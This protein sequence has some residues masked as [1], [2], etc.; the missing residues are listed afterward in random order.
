MLGSAKKNELFLAEIS[1]EQV[2]CWGHLPHSK[3]RGDR[4]PGGRMVRTEDTSSTRCNHRWI[5]EQDLS[6]FPA[7]ETQVLGQ[8]LSRDCV[9]WQEAGLTS[10]EWFRPAPCRGDMAVDPSWQAGLCFAFALPMTSHHRRAGHRP[11][12]MLDSLCCGDMYGLPHWSCGDVCWRGAVCVHL[13]L[14]K[15]PLKETVRC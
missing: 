11:F 6:G 12:L 4:T 5:S 9:V 15:P 2:R 10:T 14:N 3:R 7:C 13:L 1:Q 8:A